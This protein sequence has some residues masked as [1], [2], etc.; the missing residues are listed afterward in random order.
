[1]NRKGVCYDVGRVLEG[2]L[3][4][5]NFDRDVIHRELEIIKNDLHCNAVRIQGFDLDRLKIA[6]EDALKQGLEVWFSPE[7]FEKSQ[8]ETYEYLLK[9]ADIA[10]SLREKYP[11]IV[12]S[13][14]SELTLFMQGILEGK[15]LME[16]MSSPSFRED[17]MTGK[18][19]GPLNTFLAKANRAVR[20]AFNANVTYFSVPGIE[21]VDWSQFDF[22]GMDLYRNSGMQDMYDRMLKLSFSYGKPVVIGEFGCCT[23]QGAEKLGA[24]GWAIAFGM[25]ADYLGPKVR[26]P[27]SFS[28]YLK[29]PAR[30]D[31]HYVRDEGLQAREIIDQLSLLDHSGVEG[32]FVFTFVSP[33]SHHNDDPRFD[34]DLPSYS[35]VKSY[36]E[37]EGLEEVIHQIAKQG[38]ELLGVEISQDALAKFATNVG[39]H[40]KTYPD[41][42]WEPKESF[43]AVAKYY[44][45]N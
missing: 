38:K 11:R 37:R 4:R 43:R 34:S 24:M 35:L 9:A 39:K 18:L 12:F 1:L 29:I 32:A 16:R 7:M 28:D 22:V 13:L 17:I 27:E 40:G 41:M 8:E 30:I 2:T 20:E 3:Q 14:G 44:A 21:R 26:L 15:N 42:T 31:G 45:R 23:Y 6:S 33:L 5:P 36:A 19:A 10:E 25:M